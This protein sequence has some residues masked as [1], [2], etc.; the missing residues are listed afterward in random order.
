VVG[1]DVEQLVEIGAHVRF[2]HPLVRSAIYSGASSKDR[3][4]AHLALAAAIDAETDPDRRAWHRALAAEG[5][6][7]EVASEL[8]RS[9]SRA[10]S[11]GGLAAAAAFLQ[12]S[13]ALT[14]DPQRRADRAL[15]ATQAQINAGAFDEALRLLAATETDTE[16]ELQRAQMELLRA[17]VAFASGFGGDAP[18]LLLKAAARLEKVDAGIARETYL[19]AWGAALF[20]GQFAGMGTLQAI[21]RAAQ[22]APRPT[23]PPRTLDVMLDGFAAL[24]SDGR[25]AAAPLLRQI[26][27]AFA[28]TEVPTDEALRVG[29]LAPVA[30]YSLWDDAS[31]Y[32]IVTRQLQLARDAGALGRLPID[33]NV[34]ATM[35]T[36]FGDFT[37]AAQAIA[38]A[39]VVAEVTGTRLAPVGA[40]CLAA[41]QG[42]QAEVMTL[43]D[44]T[45]TS[46]TAR[47]QG[48]SVQYANWG[49][50][51]LF[52]GLGRYA[53]AVS[54]SQQAADD[55]P[56]LYV[57]SWA[58][59][60][61][62]EAAV[63]TG[64]VQLAAD[65]VDRFVVAT[66]A[67]GSDWARGI[68]ARS[69]A[70][71]NEG[72][73]ADGLYREA[74]DRLT[75]TRL[76]PE[77]ARAHL[78]YGEWLRRQNRRVDARN[79]LRSAYD[80]F[81]EIGMLA[82]AERTTHELEATGETVRKRMTRSPW[83]FVAA[84]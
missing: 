80:M 16:T 11:R 32:A 40:L 22:A 4:A 31:L 56:E 62:V 70:L 74:V 73:T 46:A 50:A 23:G 82:F 38:E 53:E 63:R 57:S 9:A 21:S 54:S 3:R 19:N 29:Q 69:R 61:L 83:N 81:S 15:A 55:T 43:I 44:A 48:V 64:R 6:D 39:A 51:V 45:V 68:E 71:V 41:S 75:R 18:G 28:G 47:G 7:E 42:R 60:E 8:E 58:L 2:R 66:E 10:Q 14:Q 26:A 12:R 20:A 52:N 59:P 72:D 13:V 25:A 67:S 49:A 65:S 24:V 33:L 79:Q 30:A 36:F 37:R 35:E 76:R 77:L 34:M 78:L 84:S 5:P 17:Q 27:S 1:A